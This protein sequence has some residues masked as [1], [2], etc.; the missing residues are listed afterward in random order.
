VLTQSLS[1]RAQF[2]AVEDESNL[3]TMLGLN[4]GIWIGG[5]LDRHLCPSERH[6]IEAF[7]KSNA[8]EVRTGAR[9]SLSLDGASL[10]VPNKMSVGVVGG[11]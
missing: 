9:P 8:A 4:E 7:V 6:A 10:R 3:L 5:K 1:G 11:R 2:A